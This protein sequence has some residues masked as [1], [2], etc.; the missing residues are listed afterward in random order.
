M[1]V[2]V[3]AT[4]DIETCRGDPQIMHE[5]LVI[6]FEF[7]FLYY[8]GLPCKNHILVYWYI[9]QKFRVFLIFLQRRMNWAYW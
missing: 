7:E 3:C 4:A 9:S 5:R 2:H 8:F 6:I 1:F